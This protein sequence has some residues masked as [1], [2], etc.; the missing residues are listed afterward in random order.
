MKGKGAALSFIFV[1]LFSLRCTAN[2][3]WGIYDMY[4]VFKRVKYLLLLSPL[5]IVVYS[6]DWAEPA[7]N[8]D[9]CFIFVFPTL[10]SGL[11]NWAF[12]L[13]FAF[14]LCSS[15][16]NDPDL[17][18]DM[19]QP[20]LTSGKY[21]NFFAFFLWSHIPWVL[22]L[23][24]SLKERGP[25]QNFSQTNEKMILISIPP[26]ILSLPNPFAPTPPFPPFPFFL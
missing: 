8:R 7:F 6:L 9:R 14:P 25:D 5:F 13:G 1:L 24:R 26:I 16:H 4:P 15:L 20:G 22:V 18:R 12:F 3:T 21:P 23:T 19:N 11:A 2:V 17:H 10:P